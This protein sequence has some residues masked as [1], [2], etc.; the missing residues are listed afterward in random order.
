MLP[1]LAFSIKRIDLG[2]IGL[3]SGY[4][5]VGAFCVWVMCVVSV[6]GSFAARHSSDAALR[7][8]TRYISHKQTLS[9]YDCNIVESDVKHHSLT[10][11]SNSYMQQYLEIQASTSMYTSLAS[12]PKNAQNC[13]DHSVALELCLRLPSILSSAALVVQCHCTLC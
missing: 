4:V 13:P 11:S 1:R 12:W 7:G 8:N 6:F 2:L 10:H 5:T 3:V 9:Q